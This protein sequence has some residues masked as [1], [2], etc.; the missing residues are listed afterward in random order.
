MNAT[1]DVHPFFYGFLL[2]EL[3]TLPKSRFGRKTKALP[4]KTFHGLSLQRKSLQQ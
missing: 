3:Y 1:I 4:D 2:E